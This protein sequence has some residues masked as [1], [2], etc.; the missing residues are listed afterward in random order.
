MIKLIS[1]R[2]LRKLGIL[3]MNRRNVG[4]IGRY[5]PRKNFRLVDNKLFTK[6]A[7]LDLG[8]PTPE[9]YGVI[10]H[11]F[12]VKRMVAELLDRE[13]FVM[14]PVQGS[15][16]KGI[17]VIVGRQGN[18]FLKP[19]G[20]VVGIDGLQRH[21]SNILAGLH[22]LGGRNDQAMI[23]ALLDFDPMMAQYSHEGVPDIRVIVFRGVPVMAMIRCAT[24]ASDGKANLHQG[25][26]GVGIDI[27]SGAS[28]A[29]VQ[30]GKLVTRHPDTGASFEKLKLPHWQKILELASGCADMCG[31]G[32]LGADIVLDRQHG[33]MLLELNARPGLSIQVA[34]QEGLIKR[35]QIANEIADQAADAAE[36]I[37]MARH[38]FN[39]ANMVPLAEQAAALS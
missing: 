19:S 5:N 18:D 8:I 31:L 37:S 16:G 36:R 3:G 30:N 10:D 17:L 7:A 22:S 1:P 29:A 14:K 15:G 9:L 24:H 39:V 26:V 23:E 20:A 27:G 12:Q 4:Y 6:T 21:A 35:L 38:E 28:V 13:S 34:N 11:Q 32:Y 25:A 2:T 33:P